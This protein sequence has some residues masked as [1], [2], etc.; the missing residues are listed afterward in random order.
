[1]FH[2]FFTIIPLFLSLH[3]HAM[4][5][6]V[7]FVPTLFV[8]IKR[9]IP[10]L[11]KL[12]F[13][14]AV[15]NINSENELEK[16]SLGNT[17]YHLLP[18]DLRDALVQ[19]LP[20]RVAAPRKT[21]AL[22][23]FDGDTFH[24]Y[25]ACQLCIVSPEN[26]NVKVLKSLESDQ[27]LYY[28]TEDLHSIRFSKDG[29]RIFLKYFDNGE[30]GA[31]A[32]KVGDFITDSNSKIHYV[33]DWI[34]KTKKNPLT[35]N[36]NELLLVADNGVSLFDIAQDKMLYENVTDIQECTKK[37]WLLVLQD[38]VLC[39]IDRTTKELLYTFTGT[40]QFII[41]PRGTMLFRETVDGKAELINLWL[42]LSHSV[43]LTLNSIAEFS[44]EYFSHNVFSED[45]NY[46]L[47]HVNTAVDNSSFLNGMPRQKI[48]FSVYTCSDLQQ[49]SFCHNCYSRNYTMK[50]AAKGKY[51]HFKEE[52]KSVFVNM[53]NLFHSNVEFTRWKNWDPNELSKQ[54]NG[55]YNDARYNIGRFIHHA[56]SPDGNY[57]CKV[58]AGY[59]KEGQGEGSVCWIDTNTNKP[60]FEWKDA[61]NLRDGVFSPQGGF[62]LL[63]SYIM[64]VHAQL[65]TISKDL[66][67]DQFLLKKLIIERGIHKSMICETAH[68]NAV[69]E[70]LTEE[71]KA[72]FD[73]YVLKS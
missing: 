38:K 6:R 43:A 72:Y 18:G 55:S 7:V 21:C 9:E 16:F 29:S 61:N 28:F 52:S 15:K 11:K 5:E 22:H 70:S 34:G 73:G 59:N 69:Y 8:P 17:H 66:T 46:F 58:R 31:Y 41:S 12:C 26:E 1:M 50:F 42:D 68:L 54:V 10:S 37:N 49:K 33:C 62:F 47:M 35:N 3:V 56:I 71:Q 67:I 19:K 45:D 13:Q 32:G 27:V 65:F 64:G 39:I 30:R 51:L 53:H 2:I 60:V 40:K 4:E 48:Y 20:G 57:M 24:P 25:D 36:N 14:Q 23:S 63:R 44:S